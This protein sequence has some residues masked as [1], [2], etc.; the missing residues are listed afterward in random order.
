MF[1]AQTPIRSSGFRAVAAAFT[2]AVVSITA[3]PAHARTSFDGVWSVL[4]AGRQGDCEFAYRYPIRIV[5]GVLANAGD[6]DFVIAGR[7]S[8][9]GALRARL[10]NGA[11]S[12]VAS[13]RLSRTAGT[14]SWYGGGC[15]GTWHAGRRG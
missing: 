7:V 13:G 10:S 12:A 15:A 5:N 2:L 1:S 3:A 8:G 9:N 4:V 6:I 11:Q 14:G